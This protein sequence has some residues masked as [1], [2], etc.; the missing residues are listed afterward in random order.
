LHRYLFDS[1]PREVPKLPGEYPA[2]PL[3]NGT[4]TDIVALFEKVA[5]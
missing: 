5:T 4:A 3:P 1:A 2:A